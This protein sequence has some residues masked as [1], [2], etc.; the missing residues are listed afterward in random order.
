MLKEP[1]RAERVQKGIEDS[2]SKIPLKKVLFFP[3]HCYTSQSDSF[4]LWFA[5]NYAHSEGHKYGGRL[6]SDITWRPSIDMTVFLVC[7]SNL[8]HE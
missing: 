4:G 7:F 1:L 6:A 5:Y 2:I 8:I 3:Q